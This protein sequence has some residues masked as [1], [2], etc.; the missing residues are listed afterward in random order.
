MYFAGKYVSIWARTTVEGIMRTIILA[1]FTA[2]AFVATAAAATTITS[3]PGPDGVGQTVLFN[4][5]SGAPAGLS[6]NY[7]ITTGTTAQLAAAPHGD[8]T[9]YLVVPGLGGTLPGSATLNLGGS[10]GNISFYWGSIDTFN[11]VTF[12]TGL[13]GTGTSLGAYTG[14]MVPGATA[15]GA[16]A[17]NAN[18]RRVFFDFGALKAGS[19]VFAS[20]NHAFE[21]DDVATAVPEPA[22]WATLIAGF[23]MVG[24]SLRRRRPMAV[25]A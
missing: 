20:T 18:N 1:A 22:I 8:L 10:F 4:F 19:V 24:V 2:A 7:S 25:T 15:D 13:G 9:P 6:G 17:T 12:Y 11:T 21:I 5:N 3:V 23:G 14:S 16:Q